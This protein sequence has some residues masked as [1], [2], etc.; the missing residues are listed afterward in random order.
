MTTT[1]NVKE[2]VRSLYEQALYH[3]T[4]EPLLFHSVSLPRNINICKLCVDLPTT[5]GADV[6][7]INFPH[8]AMPGV[9]DAACVAACKAHENCDY[10]VRMGAACYLKQGQMSETTD[11]SCGQ[12][13]HPELMEKHFSLDRFH[14]EQLTVQNPLTICIR[15][16]FYI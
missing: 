5:N 12:D 14:M 2:E 16:Y 6:Y 11:N 1:Y 7:N 3:H 4:F 10:V 9:S 15:Q 8:N 13:A